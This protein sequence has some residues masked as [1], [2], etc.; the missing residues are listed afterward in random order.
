MKARHRRPQVK[1]FLPS[2]VSGPLVLAHQT[3]AL[4]ARGMGHLWGHRPRSA[5]LKASESR[6]L[7]E[8]KARVTGLTGQLKGCSEGAAQCFVLI[9]SEMLT[10]A[11]LG[12]A[13]GRPALWACGG[14]SANSEENPSQ[15]QRG[16][17]S[18]QSWKE[19]IHYARRVAGEHL[20]TPRLWPGPSPLL[21]RGQRQPRRGPFRSHRAA[22]SCWP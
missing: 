12:A 16:R 9:M 6:G 18:Q 1:G 13:R 19:D 22:G 17:A 7:W 3:R 8:D 14:A 20:D 2:Q 4:A 11:S 10:W 21:P 15:Q 5:L